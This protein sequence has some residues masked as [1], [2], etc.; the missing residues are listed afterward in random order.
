MGAK[1]VEIKYTGLRFGEKLY[2]EVLNSS[3]YTIPTS[4]PKIKVATVRSYDYDE[5]LRF[6]NELLELSHKGDSMAIVA[7]MKE[8]V[9]EFKS[10]NSIYQK[11]D[12]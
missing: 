10:I 8:M 1:G 6:E 7:K 12:K 9:P 2:E 3:E 11:L 5:A 4:N